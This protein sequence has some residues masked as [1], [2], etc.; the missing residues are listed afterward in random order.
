MLGLLLACLTVQAPAVE[1]T[2][3]AAERPPNVLLILADDL[4]AYDLGCY[5]GT[6]V[7]TPELDA[8][9]A[10]GLRVRT[11]WAT[12]LCTTSRIELVTGKYGFRTGVYSNSGSREFDMA[13]EVTFERLLR[14]RGYATAIA[15]KW[16]LIGSPAAMGFDETCLWATKEEGLSYQQGLELPDDASYDGP[17][18][19]GG[20]TSRYWHPAVLQNGVHRPTGPDDYGPDLFADF[21]IDFMRRHRERPFLAF[22][23]MCLPHSE[24]SLEQG[25][26]AAAPVPDPSAPGGRRDGGFVAMKEHLDTLVGRVLAAVDELGLRGETVVIFT[27]DNGSDGPRGKGWSTEA[28][29]WVPLIVRGPGVEPGRVSDALVDHSD[30]LPTLAELAGAPIPEGIDGRSFVPVLRGEPGPREWIFSFA[31]GE[32]ILRDRR[33]L[34]ER[35]HESY[36]GDFYD[37]GGRTAGSAYEEANTAYADATDSDDPEAVAARARFERILQDLPAP[38]YQPLK[39][40]RRA[41]PV[42]KR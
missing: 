36:P 31:R 24:K 11:C 18:G 40:A 15:G 20:V 9:A 38:R 6:Q 32:R 19:A 33:W 34:L 42:R 28:A 39:G 8:L 27:S 7:R 1:P 14:A 16:G 5:G 12:P 10:E 30:V 41:A 37:T 2:P 23:S 22:W 4:G 21:L 3:P 13:R 35:N 29:V 25:G 17:R 26:L